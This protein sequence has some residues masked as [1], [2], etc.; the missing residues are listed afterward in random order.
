MRD[1]EADRR[2]CSHA[3]KGNWKHVFGGNL[4]YAEYEYWQKPIANLTDINHNGSDGTFIAA[5]HDG[6][7]K[8]LDRIAEVEHQL[9]SASENIMLQFGCPA[10]CYEHFNCYSDDCN[11]SIKQGAI[12]W[13]KC[14]Q[15]KRKKDGE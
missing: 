15:G 6:W 7:P 1:F 11:D 8:A 4:I 13:R 14:W 2:I 5:A 12:C 3:T 9:Q 10:D